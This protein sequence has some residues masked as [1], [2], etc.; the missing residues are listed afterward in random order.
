MN[1]YF[2]SF[3]TVRVCSNQFYMIPVMDSIL[4]N[5]MYKPNKK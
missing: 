1:S 4:S 5:Y 3:T 2:K